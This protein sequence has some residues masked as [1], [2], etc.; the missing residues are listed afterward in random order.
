MILLT[1]RNEKTFNDYG[2]G[3]VQRISLC[4]GHPQTGGEV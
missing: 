1:N 4:Q 2:N 3:D